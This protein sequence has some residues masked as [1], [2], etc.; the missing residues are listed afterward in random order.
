MN[1][2]HFRLWCFQ[3]TVPWVVDSERRAAILPRDRTVL[4]QEALERRATRTTVQPNSNLIICILVLGGE[5]PEV[6]LRR[7]VG[8][9]ADGKQTSV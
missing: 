7:L 3:L 5:E 8:L 4:L 9:V 6:E 2:E 1:M